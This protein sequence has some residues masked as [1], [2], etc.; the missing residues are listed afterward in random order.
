MLLPWIYVNVLFQILW[1][2]LPPL[3]SL[4]PTGT[5]QINMAI[6]QNVLQYLGFGALSVIQKP[7]N[8]TNMILPMIF[9]LFFFL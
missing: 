8:P 5:N 1:T 2:N 7:R 4:R 6:L 9:V 3:S